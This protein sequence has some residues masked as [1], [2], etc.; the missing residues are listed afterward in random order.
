MSQ[1]ISGVVYIE[2]FITEVVFYPAAKEIVT[3][4]L[5]DQFRKPICELADVTC[6]MSAKSGSKIELFNRRRSFLL[7]KV[8]CF[9]YF[10]V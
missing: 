10:I 7:Q 8:K 2:G 6:N 3:E 4:D 1:T 5:S 9:N